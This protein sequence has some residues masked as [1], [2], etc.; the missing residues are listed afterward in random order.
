MKKKTIKAVFK[1]QNGSC[2]YK[3]NK[4]YR[5][6]IWQHSES[7]H[8]NIAIELA[9]KPDENYCEYESI[10]SFLNNWDNITVIKETVVHEK[11]EKR[12]IG[13][14]RKKYL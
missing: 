8:R 6:T 14:N 3:T 12:F 4:E 10:V 1:G 5:L 2:G 11:E 7:G 9:D 13:D